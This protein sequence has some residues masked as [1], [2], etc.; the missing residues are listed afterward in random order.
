MLGVT[1]DSL[2]LFRNSNRST[3][4]GVSRFLFFETTSP[5]FE[6]TLSQ[7]TEEAGVHKNLWQRTKK[8]G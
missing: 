1:L 6:K 3:A 2:F 5:A 4:F 8:F 7:G